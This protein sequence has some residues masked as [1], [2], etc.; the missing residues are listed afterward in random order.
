ML[1][2]H[3]GDADPITVNFGV[4]DLAIIK[5]HFTINAFAKDRRSHIPLDCH[6]LVLLQLQRGLTPLAELGLC[7]TAALPMITAS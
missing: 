5:F 4:R 2:V 7:H 6:V 1:R 3:L